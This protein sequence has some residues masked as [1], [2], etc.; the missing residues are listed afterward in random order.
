MEVEYAFLADAAAT[1]PDN[2]LYILGGGIDNIQV[3]QA[4]LVHPALAL[5]VK[6][7]LHAMECDQQHHLRI[8]LWDED[9]QAIG[10]QVGGEFS[11]TRSTMPS[12][13]SFVQLVINFVGQH[14][15]RFGSYTFNIAVDGQ[16][17]KVVPLYID[18]IVTGDRSRHGHQA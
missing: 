17:L 6:L 4:P 5:V 3:G 13:P 8:E 15:P 16:V 18:R 12:R 14:F 7:K 1:P 9:G 11:A 10:P 2:K